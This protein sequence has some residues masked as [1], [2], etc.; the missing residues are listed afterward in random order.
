MDKQSTLFERFI[1]H[2]VY[3]RGWGPRTT[4]LYRSVFKTLASDTLTKSAL[5]DWLIALRERGASPAYCN[6]GN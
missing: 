6:I 2:G 5:E 3:L 1:R 4:K